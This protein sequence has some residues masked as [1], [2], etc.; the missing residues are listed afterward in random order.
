M[1]LPT[2]YA[3]ASN[4]SVVVYDNGSSAIRLKKHCA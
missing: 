1:G 2:D 4:S 3:Y